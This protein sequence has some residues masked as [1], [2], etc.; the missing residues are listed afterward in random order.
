MQ[1]PVEYHMFRFNLMIQPLAGNETPNGQNKM[2]EAR[3]QQ[4]CH[5]ADDVMCDGVKTGIRSWW[6][7]RI[8]GDGSHPFASNASG[9][10]ERGDKH[11]KLHNQTTWEFWLPDSTSDA[12]AGACAKSKV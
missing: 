8:P 4:Y 2:T 11:G 3:K 12:Q 6:A 1:T 10:T 5:R 9:G 7:K